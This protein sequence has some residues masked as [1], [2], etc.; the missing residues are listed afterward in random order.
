MRR[1]ARSSGSS[2]VVVLVFLL[3]LQGVLIATASTT[4][5][6]L[7]EAWR[8]DAS[9]QAAALAEAGVA[10]ARAGLARDPA[11]RGADRV[12]L[13]AGAFDVSVAPGEGGRRVVRSAGQVVALR[14]AAA[15]GAAIRRRLEVT[16]AP[17]A[18]G[19]WQVEAWTWR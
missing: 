13:D 2:L 7:Q 3:L 17:D 5:P 11:F 8:T 4:Q 15:R 14:P 9:D 18:T 6:L 19:G 1:A 10:Y 16:L 12:Q